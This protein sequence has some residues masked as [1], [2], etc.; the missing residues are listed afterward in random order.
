MF[1][2]QETTL[3]VFTQHDNMYFVLGFTG[4]NLFLVHIYVA[5]LL[6]HVFTQHVHAILVV[7]N[8]SVFVHVRVTALSNSVLHD[9][10]NESKYIPYFSSSIHQ[11]VVLAISPV[12]L[13]ILISSPHDEARVV[14]VVVQAVQ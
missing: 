12:A 8:L 7:D 1:T 11:S 13:S 5:A 14:V 9:I 3:L 4:I 10:E 6:S 2:L